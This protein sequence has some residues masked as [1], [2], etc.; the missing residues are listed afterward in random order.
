MCSMSEGNSA[1]RKWKSAT[2][3]LLAV[4]AGAWGWAVWTAPLDAIQG[5]FGRIVF[6][7]P[8]LAFAAYVGFGLTALGGAGYLAS[9]REAWDRFAHA[10]AEV[11]VLFCTLMLATAVIWARAAWGKWWSW[12]P[13]TT[14]TLLLYLIY[15]AYL[16]LRAYAEGSERAARFSAVYAIASLAVVPLN[17]FAIDLAGGRAI[18]P[19]NISRG[20]FGAGMLLPFLLG[21]AAVQAAFAFLLVRRVEVGALRA[22]RAE[23]LAIQLEGEPS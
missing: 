2:A 20:T 3:A 9:R 17:Y 14:V 23:L 13:R 22:S 16:L 8:P 5:D 19:D 1:M 18:H 15:V 11:G 7:H 12:D 4:L 21:V 10:S 6:V